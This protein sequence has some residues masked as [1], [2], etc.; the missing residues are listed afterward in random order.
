MNIAEQLVEVLIQAGVRRVYGVAGDSLNPIVDAIRRAPGIDWVHVHNEEAGAFA[1]CAEAQLTGRLAVCAGSSG[2]GNTHLVQGLY[3]ANRSGAP[4]LALASHIQSN[5]IGTGFFQE[6]HP[7]RTFQDC[8][9]WCELVTPQQMPRALRVAIQTAV[10]RRGVSVVVLPGD[11]A[12][13][14]SGGPTVPSAEVPGPSRVQPPEDQVRQ[15]AEAIDR[16]RTVTLFCGAGCRDAHDE[17]M[18]LAGKVLAPVGHALGGK[19]WIQYDNPFDVGMSGLLGYG[20]AH[21]ATHEADL[22]VLLG[23][24]FP[25]PIFRPQRGPA[26]VDADAARL[27]RRTPLEVA[28]HGDVGLT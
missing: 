15:L 17:V 20:A 14:E 18:E 21:K 6:T 19:E 7:E 3:D 12:A 24:D 26:Q 16:A 13:E 23:T 8:S 4:V 22:L 5:E 11:L 10:G 1:A 2:P 27:G 25:S 9:H 28:V